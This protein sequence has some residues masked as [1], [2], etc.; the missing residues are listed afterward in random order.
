M[1]FDFGYKVGISGLSL[2]KNADHG[3]KMNEPDEMADDHI[4]D[5]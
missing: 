2:K 4:Y 3:H 5:V 1:A